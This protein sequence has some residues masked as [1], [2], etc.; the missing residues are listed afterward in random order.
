MNDVP[1]AVLYESLNLME[2]GESIE[3]ILS[4]YP[5][6]ATGLRPFLETAAQLAN[7]APQPS[8]SAKQKS[9]KVFLDHAASLKV[10]PLKPSPWY[11]IRQ[12]ILPLASLAIVL[13]LMATTAFSVSA[14]AI[15]G[16]ALYSVKRLVENVRLA[17]ADDPETAVALREEYRLERI[18][19]IQI[20]LRT[21]RSVEVNFTG[22]VEMMQE[23]VWTIEDLPVQLDEA[24][25]V[26]G[27]PQ[28]G[29]MAR[30]NGRTA[31]GNLI[32]NTIQI[33]T[34][35]AIEPEATATPQ[36]TAVPTIAATETP[37]AEP[38]EESTATVTSTATHTVTPQP[39]ATL[40]PS[41]TSSPWPTVTATPTPMP[42]DPPDN[43]NGDD[44]NTNDNNNDNDDDDDSNENG[45]EGNN[46]D[47]GDNE[48][49]NDDDDRDNSGSGNNNNDNNNDNDDD[50]DDDDD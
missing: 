27:R 34:G 24:T 18:R 46:N 35:T 19:E 28:I 25:V 29:E 30:V 4:R 15:P 17:R 16:D 12:A 7:L 44:G 50:D 14:S 32:A 1:E 23:Y 3:Q 31:N 42:T 40:T 43:D 39:T 11:R 45:D 36:P 22:S 21:G 49:D 5:E 2:Q 9:K 41:A 10:S 6:M 48:N 47:N 20:V 38:T 26:E 8:L 37:T 13:I 33:L